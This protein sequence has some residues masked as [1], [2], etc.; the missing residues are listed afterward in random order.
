MTA[1]EYFEKLGYMQEIIA[2]EICYTKQELLA[3][4]TIIFNTKN[5][6]ISFLIDNKDVVL[7][8][9]LEE[10]KAINKQVEELGWLES[11]KQ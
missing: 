10:I 5:K 4:V 8:F 6:D 3:L 7:N 2:E 9:E 11:E 1:R